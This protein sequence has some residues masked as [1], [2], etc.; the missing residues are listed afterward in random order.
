M[1]VGDEGLEVGAQSYRLL[2]S[3]EK[4]KRRLRSYAPVTGE[5]IVGV[6]GG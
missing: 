2:S 1:D 3:L 4:P 5:A 6:F